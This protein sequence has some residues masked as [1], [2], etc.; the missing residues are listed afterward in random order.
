L[1]Y[2]PASNSTSVK[3]A[4]FSLSESLTPGPVHETERVLASIFTQVDP[5]SCSKRDQA[6]MCA[7]LLFTYSVPRSADRRYCGPVRPPVS[8][9]PSPAPTPPPPPSSGGRRYT[10]WSGG[11]TIDP[12]RAPSH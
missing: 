8:P 10:G 11:P 12:V 9:P 5:W 1:T 3:P 4:L 2:G 7:R 6:R